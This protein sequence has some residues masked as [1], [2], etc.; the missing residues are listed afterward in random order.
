MWFMS[1]L[2]SMSS[3]VEIN[4]RRYWKLTVLD[5]FWNAGETVANKVVLDGIPEREKLFSC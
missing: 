2:G 4:C 5:D 3:R 1:A